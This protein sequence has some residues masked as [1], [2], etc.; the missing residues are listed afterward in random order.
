MTNIKKKPS[1]ANT[2]RHISQILFFILFPGMFSTL[3]NVLKSLVQ[4]AS[5][6]GTANMASAGYI[7]LFAGTML[8][9]AVFGRFF[10][11]FVCSFGA[12]EDLL[13]AVSQ[14]LGIRRITV[15]AEA[16]QMLKALKYVILVMI[17]FGLWVLQL[18]AIPS[19]ANPWNVFGMYSTFAGWT[20]PGG[21][22]TIGGVLLLLIAAASLFIERFF[23]RYL[24]PL[25]AVFSVLAK[26]RIF[27]VKKERNGCGSCHLCNRTCSMGIQMD[28]YDE[29]TS[30][31]CINCFNCVTQCR[32][33]NATADPRPAMVSAVSVAA[34]GGLV[35]VGTI[36]MNH[37]AEAAASSAG[38][39]VAESAAQGQYQDGT[40]TG[41]GKGFRGNTEV[42]V[43]VN[44]GNITDIT[45]VSYKD[46][47]QYFNRAKDTIISEIIEAQDTDVSA[48]S[49]A[50]FS[51]NGIIS[52]V[53]DAM[54]GMTVSASS[55]V[56]AE[57]ETA[58]EEEDIQ[59][60]AAAAESEEQSQ[61]SA[62][63]A[64]KSSTDSSTAVYQDGTY[65]GSGTGLRGETEVSVKVEG[66]R[67][68][69]ITVVSYE[70]DEQFFERAQDTV[71][72]EILSSQNV[73]VSSV[74][75]ATFSS[76]S[77][78]AA[79]A[80]AL[81]ISYTNENTAQGSVQEGGHGGRGGRGGFGKG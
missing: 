11:G 44:N 39:V 20:S 2:A 12:M 43:T 33:G 7:A 76:N 50:T 47:D 55:A 63:A 4:A 3:F 41:T 59:Q 15:P 22:V 53:Q 75:G 37:D 51:S 9:T 38:T 68:T 73:N 52:A 45:I 40:Y 30:G 64:D 69:D 60:S 67:I 49:G 78:K 36:T 21:F 77:I 29:I 42:S 17:V 35:C 74:S 24:C 57:S 32:K 8:I 72:S 56:T 18:A 16:D 28:Q 25:G 31:E 14:K 26:L 80:D 6:Q 46:D 48:V 65:T 13:F 71:I 62:A 19:D 27:H 1:K 34:I 79:V 58:P 70:D 61:T 10:C 5:G 66:G 23:C 81:N 54:S